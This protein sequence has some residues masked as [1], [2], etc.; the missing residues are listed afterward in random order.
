MPT[1][2]KQ[3]EGSLIRLR[4]R[5]VVVTSAIACAALVL[6]ACGS[7]SS[8][9]QSTATAAPGTVTIAG[10]KAPGGSGDL[11]F[12]FATAPPY[13]K[14]CTAPGVVEQD[15]FARNCTIPYINGM[16][17]SPAGLL[18]EHSNLVA[19]ARD[20]LLKKPASGKWPI[21]YPGGVTAAKDD[22]NAIV[23]SSKANDIV[24]RALPNPLPIPGTK[25]GEIYQQAGLLYL[26]NSYVVP[27]GIFNEQYGWDSFFIAKGLLASAENVMA[28][29]SGRYFDPATSTFVTL[30]DQTAP[31]YASQLFQLA[32]GMLDNAAFEI[33]FYGGMVNNGNRIYYLTR[34]QP[35]FFAHEALAIYDFQKKY[36]DITPYKETLAPYFGITA[37]TNYEEWLAKEIAPMARNYF[38]YYTDPNHVIFNEKTN[39]RVKT[40]NGRQVSLYVTDGVGPAPE[41]T[42]SQVPGNEGFYASVAAYFKNYPEANPGGVFWKDNGKSAEQQLTETYYR[43]DRTTRASGYDLSGRYG[44]VGQWSAMYAPIDL[45]ALNYQSALDI[46]QIVSIAKDQGVDSN[47][48]V[49]E[50]QINSM[51]DTINSLFWVDSAAGGQPGSRWTDVFVGPGP[52][53]PQPY[54]YGT[55][56]VPMWAS[57]LA[58]EAAAKGVLATATSSTPISQELIAYAKGTNGKVRPFT[59]TGENGQML[60]C[61]KGKPK[62]PTVV[63]QT[64]PPDAFLDANNYG[65]PTS[66][67]MTGNQWDYPNAWAPIQAFA[68]EG[69]LNSG[70]TDESAMVDQGWL[71]S[72]DVGFAH[73]GEIV[74]KY[75]TNNPASSPPV[76]AGYSADQAG[77]GW[78]NAVYLEAWQRQ[79]G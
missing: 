16:W 9:G 44:Y 3:G 12:N 76:T 15:Q 22:I 71:N 24:V 26:P 8:N 54:A 32:K 41:I 64:V 33:R 36:P 38:D 55:T 39:P 34:S 40:V 46:N 20:W 30:N 2:K 17:N 35:P 10:L 63:G 65:V 28:N 52:T 61:Q 51:K 5:S 56:F 59:L 78:T 73:A 7:T 21:Y 49:P 14:S 53:Q 79:N 77:F 66:L 27:G 31:Q 11:N 6:A 23:K 42:D 47:L 70:F 19:A 58:P 43:S 74:E 72:V 62:C 13:I 1:T 18:R 60:E 67:V 48:A 4:T 45:Q 75:P 29:R 68:S 25:A 37:P 57:K 50:D 69:L